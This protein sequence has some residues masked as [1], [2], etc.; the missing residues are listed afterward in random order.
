[1]RALVVGF[2]SE[3]E[4]KEFNPHLDFTFHI[5][6]GSEFPVIGIRDDNIVVCE[7]GYGIVDIR[8]DKVLLYEDNQLEVFVV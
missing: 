2:I 3:E 1:M 7:A 5:T 4:A 6:K 8:R